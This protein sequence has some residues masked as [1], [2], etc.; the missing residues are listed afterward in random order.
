MSDH[1]DLAVAT[2]A[3]QA[4]PFGVLILNQERRVLWLNGVAEE[5]LNVEAERLVGQGRDTVTAAELDYLFEPKEM[6]SVPMGSGTRWLKCWH[7]PL[8]LEDRAVGEIYFYIDVTEYRRVQ[9]ER[10]QLAEDL[11]RQSVR[12]PLTGLPNRRG[13]MQGLE[14]QVA[15]SRRYGNPL[16][17]IRMQIDDIDQLD[18][19]HGTTTT[20][21]VIIAIGQ[22]LRD[23]TR[24]ADLVGC[25]DAGEFFMILPETTKGTAVQLAEKFCKWINGFKITAVDNK[26][27]TVVARCGVTQW[28]KGDD[29][30]KILRRTL[31]ALKYIK[32]STDRFVSAL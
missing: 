31:Q 19:R 6:V 18:T 14:P 22:M 4:A 17:V 1:L 12:D 7:L 24:W 11:S 16:S 25:L 27:I 5:Y 21:R 30:A 29:S 26:E 3:L 32:K 2:A 13:L 28:I 9:S 23:Q 10:D 8:R 15:R 20:D